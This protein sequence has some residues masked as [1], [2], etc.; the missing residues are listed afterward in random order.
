MWPVHSHFV[1]RRRLGF[2]GLFPVYPAF[3]RF[4][5]SAAAFTVVTKDVPPWTVVA[6][7]P[8]RVIRERPVDRNEWRE[9]F[10]QLGAKGAGT[11]AGTM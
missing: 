10:R 9:V 4:P 11:S 6:G 7:N 1:S 3:S 2:S 8:A 5:T